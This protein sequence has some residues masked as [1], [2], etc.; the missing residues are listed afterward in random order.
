MNVYA[1]HDGTTIL[2]AENLTN[3]EA[4]EFMLNT[5]VLDYADETLGY[6]DDVIFPDEMYASD[7]IPFYEPSD[8]A[9]N[10]DDLDPDELPF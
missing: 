3:D 9:E 8:Q 6:E 2:L 10:Y 7:E 5:Y 4:N 1:H